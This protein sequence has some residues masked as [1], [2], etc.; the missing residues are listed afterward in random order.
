MKLLI[1]MKK[2]IFGILLLSTVIFAYAK[3]PVVEQTNQMNMTAYIEVI[4]D[5]TI[6]YHNVYGIQVAQP[7]DVYTGIF[8]YSTSRKRPMRLVTMNSGAY[9]WQDS[10]KTLGTYI[11]YASKAFDRVILR[12]KEE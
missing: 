5:S 6:I 11:L 9:I 10:D 4:N 8:E 1:N 3:P 7:K 2:L 12:A